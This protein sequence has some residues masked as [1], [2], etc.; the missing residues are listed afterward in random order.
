MRVFLFIFLLALHTSL[1][2]LEDVTVSTVYGD[3]VGQA[4][5]T[6]AG[7]TI[8]TFL[9]VPFAL[10]PV[11]DLRFTVSML[12]CNPVYFTISEI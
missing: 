11:G 7:K 8:N 10:P 9:G 5:P 12:S 2:Q 6:A 1:A 4:V 3:V